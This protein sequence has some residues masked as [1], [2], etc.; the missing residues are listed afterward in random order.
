MSRRILFIDDQRMEFA[1][2]HKVFEGFSQEKFTLEWAQT[3]EEGLT[4]LT[5]SRYAAC[6]LDYNLGDQ[7]GLSLLKA[8]IAGGC[9]TPIIFL[10]AETSSD[11]GN[12][13]MDAGALDFWVKSELR[14]ETVERSLL[15][16]LRLAQ[17]MEELRHRATR[18]DLTQ[19]LNRREFDSIF[20][21]ETQRALQFGNSVS[22]VLIDL[23]FFKLVNDNFGHQVGDRVLRIVAD[24]LVHCV[25]AIDRVARIGGEEFAIIL[26]DTDRL[27]ALEVA[28]RIINA[29]QTGLDIS[30][31]GRPLKGTASGGVASIPYHGNTVASIMQA[32]DRALYLSKNRGRNQATLALIQEATRPPAHSRDRYPT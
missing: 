31:E 23:D 25:R 18:D 1:L 12:T 10:T 29:V 17:T 5:G 28:R 13:A 3:Y 30:I 2:L 14:P 9:T 8:A 15:F 7:N 26:I 4:L 20:K 19:L 21:E 16:A 27:V 11:V 22:L 32:A 6:L 24:I